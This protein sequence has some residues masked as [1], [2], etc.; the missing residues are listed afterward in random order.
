MREIHQIWLKTMQFTK[1][2]N[3]NLSDPISQ[4]QSKSIHRQRVHV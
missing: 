2:I 1:N 4:N 3:I